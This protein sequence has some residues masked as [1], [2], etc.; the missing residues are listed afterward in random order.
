MSNPKIFY[1]NHLDGSGL[2][3][4]T[5]A[6]GYSVDNL[7]DWRPYTRWKST[8][9][10]ATITRDYGSALAADY[11]FVC[12]QPATYEFHGSTDNFAS[13]DV[14][15]GSVTLTKAG[16]SLG[17]A[18]FGSASYRYWR[19]RQTGTGTPEVAIAAIGAAL[20]MPVPLDAGFDPLR[21][22]VYGQRNQSEKGYGLG[23]V[24]DFE[25]WMQTLQFNWV[26]WAFV[27]STFDPAW[28]AHLRDKPFA[29][30]WD[31]ATYA[32]EV[33]LVETGEQYETAH[34]PGGWAHLSFDVSGV[35]F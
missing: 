13:S 16:F 32:G 2:S 11:G 12:G 28:L 20:E 23:R 34:Q 31:P 24:T 19:V 14:L 33:R 10:P 6:A 17:L 7:R 26:T 15:L 35:H 29:F 9:L 30:C 1:Q 25:E 5:T 4:S 27:R 18:V 21:R 8:A 3:A 22:K